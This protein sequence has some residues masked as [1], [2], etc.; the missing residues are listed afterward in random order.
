MA[1]ESGYQTGVIRE[2]GGDVWRITSAGTLVLST[3]GTLT[4][5]GNQTVLGG[6]FRIAS[7]GALTLSTGATVIFNNDSTVIDAGTVRF[8]SDASLVV[9]TAATMTINN[10]TVVDAGTIRFTSDAT[11]LI[12]T[13]ATFNRAG[14]AIT[15]TATELNSVKS[16]WYDVYNQGTITT[17]ANGVLTMTLQFVDQAG[18]VVSTAQSALMYF[19]NDAAG[20]TALSTKIG[21]LAIS[22]DGLLLS[23]SAAATSNGLFRVV[24]ESD[25]DVV[26]QFNGVAQGCWS[27]YLNAVRPSGSVRAITTQAIYTIES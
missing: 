26:I 2:Q 17:A 9:S 25:G 22:G 18:S 20:Q 23:L 1:G 19:S 13:A 11:L 6:T 24:S 27:G 7:G 16:A 8:T 3:S 14:T 15:A 4:Q 12:S 5:Y 21:A 10:T